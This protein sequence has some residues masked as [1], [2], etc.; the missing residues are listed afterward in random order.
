MSGYD[1][2]LPNYAG[3][4]MQAYDQGRERQQRSNLEQLA[5][6]YFTKGSSPQLLGDIARNGGNAALYQKNDQDNMQAQ[7][8]QVA[9]FGQMFL[10][11][12]EDQK[13]QAYPQFAQM[14]TAMKLPH[15]PIP[16]QYDPN[17][18]PGITKFISAI[19]GQSGGDAMHPMNVSPGGAV[20]DPYTGKEIY[21]NHNFAPQRPTYDS[22]RGGWAMPP[23][24]QQSAPPPGN[25]DAILAQANF[26][27]QNGVPEAKVQEWLGQ[28]PGMTPVA[29]QGGGG[30]GGGP[31][32]VQV[33]PP[34]PDYQAQRIAIE[35]ERLQMAKDAAQGRDGGPGAQSPETEAAQV[36]A[37]AEGRMAFPTGTA[38]KSPYWQNMLSKVA[39]YDPSFDAVNYNARAK[40]RSEFT[41]GKSA[42]NIKALNTLAGHIA[43]FLVSSRKLNNT[44]FGPY[45]SAKN[46]LAS[47]TGDP[48]IS[49][50]NANKIAI[51]NELT[52][53]FRGS[54]GNESDVQA[55]LKEI[56]GAKSPAQFHAVVKKIAELV[57]S[58]IN[59]LSEQ[60][61]QGMGTTKADRPFVTPENQAFFDE[62]DGAK[63]PANPAHAG[64]RV[65][66]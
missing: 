27:V 32:F 60:Y 47:A 39:A 13:A 38:L 14:V 46:A 17:F 15:P 34:K 3:D 28:Q 9:Q 55:W 29:D 41:S 21:A 65:L 56:D 35:R 45:N 19:S 51:S 22:A 33:A 12:P 49:A 4:M 44:N 26:M 66:D 18:V 54:S 53:V 50:F 61:R 62:L 58:R 30:G 31:G 1:Q 43:G 36:K 5:G 63:K 52:T 25:N 20:V 23:G 48:D 6:D 24:G 8:Q 57:Q 59:A 64:F 10:A 37:L 7:A 11:L 40:T 42:N 2:F 16:M